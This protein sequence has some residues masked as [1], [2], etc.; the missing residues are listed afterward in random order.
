MARIT[1]VA[2]AQKDQGNCDHCHKPINKGD[3]YFWVALKPSTYSSIK[4]KRHLGCPTWRP[5]E[6]T[7]S[8]TKSALY[9]GLEAAE[10]Q[11]QEASCVDDVRSALEAA[12]DCV[13]EVAQMFEES[14][15]N[16]EDGFGHETEKSTEL[17]ERGEELSGHA[18][19]IEDYMNDLPE[20]PEWTVVYVGGEEPRD[21]HG[22]FDNEDDARAKCDELND[23]LDDD[24]WEVECSDTDFD[25]DDIVSQAMDIISNANCI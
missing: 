23:P 22:P 24:E 7:F 4:K 14:A 18:D 3:A 5:S 8:P 1:N 12:A 11:L 20:Q 19:E 13:R 25:F 15:D 17:R 2:K 6:L 16:M 9:A 21:D 10:D